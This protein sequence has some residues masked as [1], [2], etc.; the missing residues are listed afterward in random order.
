VKITVDRDPFAAAVSWVAR[1]LPAKPA[2][3]ALAC[4]RLR[5]ADELTLSV[6]DYDVSAQATVPVTAADGDT[7][8]VAGRLFAEIVRSLPAQPV[9]LSTGGARMVL[10]C[11]ASRFTLTALAAEG[12]PSPPALPP[13]AGTLGSDVLAAAAAQVAVAAGKDETL[14]ALTGVRMEINGNKIRLVATDRFRLAVKELHWDPAEP[15]I[16]A[17]VLVPARVLLDATRTAAPSAE[18]SVCLAAPAPDGND[19]VIGFAAS[20]QQTTVRLLSSEYPR[21]EA[22]LPTEFSSTA[23]IPAGLL[24]DAVKRVALVAE[25]GTPVRL[26]FSAGQLTLAAGSGNEAQATEDL[27]VAFDGEDGVQIA[28]SPH[29][30]L[31]GIGAAASDMIRLSLT[32]PTKAALITGKTGGQPDYRYLLMP[33]RTGG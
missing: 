15:D 25:G 33:V 5:G 29:Y 16:A 18:M 23:E 12:Y 21:Y 17:T 8:M 32:A 10:S 1:A 7:A 6:F 13:L 2:A 4:M 28:F 3:P 20:G 11:G 30:L 31:D 27:D 14:P 26:T 24:A 9:T 19:A 22:L